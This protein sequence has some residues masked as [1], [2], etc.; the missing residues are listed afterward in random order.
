[1]TQTCEAAT[2]PRKPRGRPNLKLGKKFSVALTMDQY[3]AINDVAVYE[4]C[5]VAPVVRR[6]IDEYLRAHRVPK[7]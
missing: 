4:G 1:M 3:I 2:A 5:D 7:L 6:A